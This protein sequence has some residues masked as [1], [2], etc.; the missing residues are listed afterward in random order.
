MVL[1]A[2]R[3]GKVSRT[4]GETETLAALMEL[5][6][7]ELPLGKSSLI[8]LNLMYI[9]VP[10]YVVIEWFLLEACLIHIFF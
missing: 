4:V 7:A 10:V 8:R 6:V 1:C 9:Y 5:L 3:R 2:Q